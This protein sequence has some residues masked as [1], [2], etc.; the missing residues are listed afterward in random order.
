MQSR[1]L[2]RKRDA[3]QVVANEAAVELP[4]PPTVAQADEPA[5]E[6]PF[7]PV[8]PQTD[9]VAMGIQEPPPLPVMV[10]T[11]EVAQ[12]DEWICMNCGVLNAGDYCTNLVRKSECGTPRGKTGYTGSA[13]LRSGAPFGSLN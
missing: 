12:A 9:E 5:M 6:P 10:Q 3:R 13:R 2:R 8:V 4:P 7:P 1:A 11:D